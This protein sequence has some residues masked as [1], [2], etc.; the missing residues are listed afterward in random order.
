MPK[1]KIPDISEPDLDLYGT[2]SEKSLKSDSK[3]IPLAN[4][5]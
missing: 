1:R 5:I 2:G 3:F 4:A